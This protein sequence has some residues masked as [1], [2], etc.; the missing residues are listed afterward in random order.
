MTGEAS[1][2]GIVMDPSRR[3]RRPKR[4]VRVVLF[5]RDTKIIEGGAL[6]RDPAREGL[7]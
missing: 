1:R 7:H 5:G 6:K 3:R 4:T 2:W